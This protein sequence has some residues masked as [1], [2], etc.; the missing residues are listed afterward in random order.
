MNDKRNYKKGNRIEIL[1]ALYSGGTLP[2][3]ALRLLNGTERLNQRLIRVMEKEGFVEICKDKRNGKKIF[4]PSCWRE[5]Y[6][7]EYGDYLSEYY[8]FHYMELETEMVKA[9]SEREKTRAERYLRCGELCLLMHKAGIGSYPEEKK[10]LA[11]NNTVLETSDAMYFNG[12]EV[13]KAAS[14]VAEVFYKDGIKQI[15]NTRLHGLV[16]SP[17]G[18]YAVYNIGRRLLEWEQYGETKMSKAINDIL[19]REIKGKR[20]RQGPIREIACILF[21]EDD[22]IFSKV[23]T[24]DTPRKKSLTIMNIEYGY[25]E[26][27]GLP[28][29]KNGIKMM[30]IMKEEKWKQKMKYLLLKDIDT[31]EESRYGIVCDGVKNKN[32]YILLFCIP[33]LQRLKMFLKRAY[34]ENNKEMFEIYCFSY[35]IPLLV[36]L[37]SNV[38]TICSIELDDYIKQYVEVSHKEESDVYE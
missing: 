32:I 24:N 25:N 26:I 31:R 8:E 36:K 11:L 30:Q 1:K 20:K 19:Y 21:G 34:R 13:K 18:D 10:L 9:K 7:R 23:I 15:V 12:M 33:N 2:Y 35:Q 37:A 6:L 5:H 29:N 22:G 27:Y 4:L 38:V 17:G 3:R 28:S 16:I 14:Y